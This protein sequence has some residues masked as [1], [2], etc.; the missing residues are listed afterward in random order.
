VSFI[1][2]P[3]SADPT[4]LRLLTNGEPEPNIDEER[5]SVIL[6]EEDVEVLVD[7][8]VQG[9]QSAKYWTCDLSHVGVAPVSRR[10]F[11]AVF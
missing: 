2:P 9:G 5:A 4:P 6:A 10:P 3:T 7:L 8:G 11:A 1:P